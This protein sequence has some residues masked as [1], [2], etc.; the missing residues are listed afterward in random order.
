[1]IVQLAEKFGISTDELLTGE[2]TA[3]HKEEINQTPQHLNFGTSYLKNGGLY[4]LLSLLFV[5]P[6]LK[7]SQ[8][9]I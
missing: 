1:M 2:E 9:K 4:S 8:V 6:S 3:L 5:V 7:Y